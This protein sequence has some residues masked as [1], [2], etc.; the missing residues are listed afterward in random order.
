MENISGFRAPESDVITSLNQ[1]KSLFETF[2]PYK[3]L[4]TG[5]RRGFEGAYADLSNAEGILS[6]KASIGEDNMNLKVY[7]GL[8]QSIANTMISAPIVIDYLISLGEKASLVKMDGEL[9]GVSIRIRLEPLNV[10]RIALLQ[11]TIETVIEL[12][13]YLQKATGV[14]N[15]NILLEEKYKEIR[16][17]VDPVFPVKFTEIAEDSLLCRMVLD[18]RRMLESGLCVALSCESDVLID[19]FLTTLADKLQKRF[20]DSIGR[21]KDIVPVKSVIDLNLKSPGYLGI[22]SIC[23]GFGSPY[24]RGDEVD[25]F[26][27]VLS[28]EKA[29]FFF[30]KQ[31]EHETVFGSGQGKIADPTK[32]TI[33]RLHPNDVGRDQIIAFVVHQEASKPDI[34]ASRVEPTRLRLQQFLQ[35]EIFQD[36]QLDLLRPMVKSMLWYNEEPGAILKLIDSKKESFRGLG[37]SIKAH[38]AEYIQKKL[39][40]GIEKG[41]LQEFAASKLIG[42]DKAIELAIIR[43][44]K[45]V[46]TRP[47]NQPLRALFQGVA[48]VGKSEFSQ[49]VAEYLGIPFYSI[50]AASFTDIHQATSMLL[51]S[52]R[53]I[54]QSYLPGKFEQ[55]CNSG[56]ICLEVAD[57]DHAPSATKNYLADLFLS[58]L[59]TGL[60]QTATG[61]KIDCTSLLIF[62]TINLPGFDEDVLK[63]VGFNNKF[64]YDD[65]L[66]KTT[67][68]LKR[69]FS[70]AFVS[71]I[72][73]PIIFTPFSF[74]EKALILEMA[75][76]KKVGICM[77][78]IGLNSTSREIVLES[79]TG[80][81]LMQNRPPVDDSLG[82][83]VL[84][85]WAGE[86]VTNVIYSSI[87]QFRTIGNA[88]VEI[89]TNDNKTIEITIKKGGKDEFQSI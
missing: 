32:P 74:E 78:N 40:D 67:K 4:S 10:T 42:Q 77:E 21:I 43:L 13:K 68:E 15:K 76:R 53:G 34:D 7:L 2:V 59:E 17:I 58:I 24:D 30:G 46:L 25:L 16:S 71:R 73:D 29:S 70:G 8:V 64:T 62:F 22:P 66:R 35:E 9:V 1:V 50:D 82:A 6:V 37:N 84:Y 72:G 86:L 23:L 51:G 39:I 57:L 20:I 85:D 89:K 31:A 79:G 36:N 45:E 44:W 11:G 3:L 56:P 41:G 81:K 33:I 75:I 5:G 18:T 19:L 54:V 63:G 28:K 27:S 61:S 47:S 52:G 14:K 48:G 83:R 12:A 26:M 55:I 38:R 69:S 87:Q 60:V 65:I 88:S 80:I 49:L